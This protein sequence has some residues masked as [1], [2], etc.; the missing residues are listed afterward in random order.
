LKVESSA[1]ETTT[2][3]GRAADRGGVTVRAVVISLALVLLLAPVNYLVELKWY[4][5]ELSS[6]V[7]APMPVVIV[8]LLAAANGLFGLTRLG[9]RFGLSRRE[10]LVIFAAVSIGAPLVT[11]GILFWILP[12][13][14]AFYYQAQIKPEWGQTF[15]SYIPLWFAPTDVRTVTDFFQGQSTVPWALWWT[16]LAAWLGFFVALFVCTLCLICIVQRQWITH[17]RLA[18]PLAQIPLEMVQERRGIGLLPGRTAW[19]FWVGVL[20]AGGINF[21]NV[22]SRKYPSLPSIPLFILAMKPVPTG[23]MAGLGEIDIVFEPW[24]IALAFLVPKELSF[25][26]WFFWI[27]N[28]ALTVL[29]VMIGTTGQAPDSY[30]TDFPACF[31]QGGGVALALL[32]WVLWIGRQ[33]LARG[34][35]LALTGGRDAQEAKEP[36]SYRWAGILMVVSFACMVYF[37][38]AAGC[39]VWFGA[40]IMGLVVAYYAMWARLRAE[41]GLGFL[42]FPLEIGNAAVSLVGSHALTPRELVALISVRWTYF[43]GFGSTAEVLTGNALESY[44]VADAA[45]VNARRLTR[46]MVACFLVALVF[47]TWVL[48]TAFYREGYFGLLASR[49][50]W[51]PYQTLN[52]GGRI[53]SALTDLNKPDPR[54]FIAIGAGAAV[55]VLLGAMRLRFWW[56]PFHPLGY[57][58]ANCWGMHWSY[59]PFFLGWVGKVLVI[60]YGGLRL[61]RAAVPLAVGIIVGQQLNAGLWAIVALWTGGRV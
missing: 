40:L 57:L 43:P 24:L 53:F 39:R 10:L 30:S 20:I 7:P 5:G 58:A 56:W 34:L 26:C 46:L 19:A 49:S 35:R 16:P 11:H 8:A 60:R 50:S 32:I 38:W 27:V 54:G 6:G 4:K 13:V 18:F 28:R 17:E 14:V 23:W 37:C 15:L 25:S 33:H 21:L 59:M 29:A 36:L 12:K 51:P 61:Y 31:Y 47:G 2:G 22:L 52:D 1:R 44:K 3:T 45:G 9:R 42:P 48:L 55:T 41:A